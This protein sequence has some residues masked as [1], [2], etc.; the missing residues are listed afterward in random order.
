MIAVDATEEAVLGILD[1]Q[2]WSR[3]AEA[4]TSTAP[5]RRQRKLAQK[6]SVRWL[7]GTIAAVHRAEAAAQVIVVGDRDSDLYA[8]FARRPER[9][10]LLVRA[11][12]DRTVQEGGRL[13]AQPAAW[14][15]LATEARHLPLRP[16]GPS[17]LA[18]ERPSWSAKAD[19]PRLSCGRTVVD[20]RPSP[21][22]TGD[23][24]KPG[25]SQHLIRL[26]QAGT[27]APIKAC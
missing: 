10:E 17:H 23:A 5:A 4:E 11:A 25:Y 12:Q 26:V 18:A 13:F 7:D 3:G 21:S 27:V 1:A 8:L 2:I 19:H 16:W 22:M 15:G 24:R 20:A 9:A 6:V 14:P